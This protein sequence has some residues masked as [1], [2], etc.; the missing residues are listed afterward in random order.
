[1]SCLELSDDGA[2]NMHSLTTG[3]FGAATTQPGVCVSLSHAVKSWVGDRP[4]MGSAALQVLMMLFFYR[5]FVFRVNGER[6]YAV[7][8]DV[9]ISACYARTLVQ[10]NGLCWYAGAPRVEGFSNPLWVLLLALV[11]AFPFFREPDLG[12]WV[13]AMNTGLFAFSYRVFW[14]IMR[15]SVSLGSV[16]GAGSPGGACC[17]HRRRKWMVAAMAACLPSMAWWASMGFEVVLMAALSLMALSL[18][19]DSERLVRSWFAIGA[20][21]GLAFWAR[22]DA[23]LYF[24]GPLVLALLS[25]NDRLRKLAWF[26]TAS[27]LAMVAL[28]IARWSYYGD[29]FPNT[30]Y[31]KLGGWGLVGRLSVGMRQNWHLCA[32]ALLCW[33]LLAMRGLRTRLGVAL[34]TVIAGLV[35]FTASVLYSVHNG[36]DYAGN[37]LG[38]DRFT[39]IGAIFLLLAICSAAVRLATVMPQRGRVWAVAW[40][41]VFLPQVLKPTPG[42]VWR[43]LTLTPP[44]PDRS[45]V[46][47]GKAFGEVSEPGAKIA[48]CAA[49]AIVY[50]SHRGGVDILGKCEP[51]VARGPVNR[52][53]RMPGHN[54]R[55]DLEVFLARHPE[56]ACIK[57]P[58]AVRHLYVRTRF[59]DHEFWARRGSA[60]VRWGLLEL[61]GDGERNN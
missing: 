21:A 44:R 25:G 29:V 40:C 51:L 23:V 12:L 28:F 56:F 35:T 43:A 49:G 42:T 53:E 45:W 1:M 26:A 9:Y 11:H 50:F 61:L 6:I 55:Y 31:L 22:M 37:P 48:I 32:A 33:G 14:R 59:N 34:R 10:G 54:K 41:I 52:P 17:P 39:A 36:G 58:T 47:Y 20:L 24:A 15:G 57:P 16:G 30:Y 4:W 18:A 38:F 5:E 19:H 13:M 46:K 27:G 2:P 7:C 3:S 60:Y 8:D